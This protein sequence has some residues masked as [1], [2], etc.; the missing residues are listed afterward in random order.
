[1]DADTPLKAGR[2]LVGHP[3]EADDKPKQVYGHKAAVIV[4]DR[5][6]GTADAAFVPGQNPLILS[7]KVPDGGYGWV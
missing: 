4:D 7:P 1:M 3:S 2:S 6:I 5:E